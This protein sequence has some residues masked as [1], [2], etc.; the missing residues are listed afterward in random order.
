M[1]VLVGRRSDRAEVEKVI[2]KRLTF[3]FILSGWVLTEINRKIIVLKMV[4]T[5]R[6]RNL[7]SFKV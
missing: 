1:V 6:S 2:K 4:D 7:Q 3:Q 5:R